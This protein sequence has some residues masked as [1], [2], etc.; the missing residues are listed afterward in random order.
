MVGTIRRRNTAPVF[1]PMNSTALPSA[2]V[3]IALAN[4]L[5]MSSRPVLSLSQEVTSYAADE[6]LRRRRTSSAVADPYRAL[7]RGIVRRWRRE[8]RRRSVGRAYDMALEV[9]KMVPKQSRVLDVGCGNG[10]IAH[11][12][13]AMLGA[14]VTG[15][16]LGATAEAPIDYQPFNGT[17]FPVSADS[18]DA[19]ILCYVLHHAQDPE[20]VLHEVR[21][22]LRPAGVA[23][24]YEDIPRRRWDRIVCGIH[25][26]K[27]RGRTGRCRFQL[28]AAWR[29]TF[30]DAGFEI[31][32]ERSLSRWRNL[33]HPV[34][35]QLFT[36][37][38]AGSQ[39]QKSSQRGAKPA[40]CLTV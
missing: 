32:T 15:I 1:T 17:T 24:V 28:A 34:R 23:V 25:N 38:I 33:A 7:V 6:E 22:A 26:R 13:A 11:H 35:R 21:R 20:V 12:L 9:A 8:R 37:K 19:V 40:D 39:T 10:Y 31:V 2:A 27:W 3:G 4:Q 36:M 14:N 29:Q 18:F 30:I 16:D 5:N